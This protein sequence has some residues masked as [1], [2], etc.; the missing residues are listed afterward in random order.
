LKP[1]FE[2]IIATIPPPRRSEGAFQLLVSTIDHSP[3]L[4]RMAIGR[5]ERGTGEVGAAVVA[6]HHGES[7]D[8]GVKARISKLFVF[9]GLERVEVEQASA[10][11]IVSVA[12]LP[13]VDIGSTICDAA[14][15]EP[16]VG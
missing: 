9:N 7:P 14:V 13:N 2:T 15:P 8:D 11:D 1:L 3:Y 16:L 6:L 10:G 5:I 12:G 4:G